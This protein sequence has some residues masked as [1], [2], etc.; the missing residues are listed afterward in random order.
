MTDG[1]KAPEERGAIN[2]GTCRASGAHAQLQVEAKGN[3]SLAAIQC[4]SAHAQ[5]R[6]QTKGGQCQHRLNNSMPQVWECIRHCFCKEGQP[7]SS[8]RHYAQ[9]FA[10][11]I[12]VG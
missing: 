2:G 3:V 1:N 12:L 7:V 9:C 10:Y 6:V 8:H 11:S 5:L 4:T